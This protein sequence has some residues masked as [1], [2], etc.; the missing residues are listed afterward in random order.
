M[1]ASSPE[2]PWDII[3][4]ISTRISDLQT[5]DTCKAVSKQWNEILQDPN[6]KIV[7][8]K[9]TGVISSAF[10]IQMCNYSW[11]TPALKSI[12]SPP[13]SSP[14][15]SI[16]LL[17]HGIVILAS[18]NQGL[19]L[20]GE[21]H[22]QYFSE[23][24]YH[25][26]KPAT[27]QWLNLP[28]PDVD[29]PTIGL[30]IAAF[31]SNPLRFKI[32]RVSQIG[33]TKSS[34]VELQCELFD[35]K[36]WAWRK[37]QNLV[38]PPKFDYM[39][40]SIFVEGSFHWVTLDNN[41]VAFHVATE[42]FRTFGM[43]KS[44]KFGQNYPIFKPRRLMDF[45]GK[46]GLSC[47]ANGNKVE[48]WL[49]MKGVWKR[50]LVVDLGRFKELEKSELIGFYDIGVVLLKTSSELI[51]LRIRDNTLEKVKLDSSEWPVTHIFQFR[52][53]FKRVKF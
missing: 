16:W 41:I 50:H 2:L 11:N 30:A 25:V 19:L 46:L 13:S 15:P 23:F 40:P 5:L 20:Y 27:G 34:G 10:I 45:Q 36:L 18:C 35:S 52:S 47:T 31:G 22:K 37:L 51:F 28:D 48:L 43:P 26:C 17:N 33:P 1:S 9:S 21:R 49:L 7:H 14:S 24:Y 39:A 32:V 4:Y 29:R 42:S 8:S 6:F 38:P 3:Y 53:D 44:M 12:H